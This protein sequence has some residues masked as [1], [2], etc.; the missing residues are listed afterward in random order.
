MEKA[1]LPI[2]R[3]KKKVHKILKGFNRVFELTEFLLFLYDHKT[4]KKIIG[5]WWWYAS[6]Y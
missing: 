1:V 3:V 2:M 6:T 4:L 5:Y